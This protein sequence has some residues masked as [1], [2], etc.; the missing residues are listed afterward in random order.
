MNAITQ[1]HY[2]YSMRHEKLLITGTK[3][4]KIPPRVIKDPS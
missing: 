2:V 4:F 3:Q 1:R